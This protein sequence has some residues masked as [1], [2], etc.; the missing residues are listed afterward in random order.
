MKRKEIA[1]TICKLATSLHRI[2]CIV[3]VIAVIFIFGE[4]VSSH[5][6][7]MFGF[8][9][10]CAVLLIPYIKASNLIKYICIGFAE[11]IYP[12]IAETNV[13]K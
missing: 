1:E 3:S 2:N 4:S 5:L 12:T 8:A 9:L 10:V 13:K 11:L 6:H 7:F